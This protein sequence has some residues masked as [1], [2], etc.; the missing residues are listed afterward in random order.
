MDLPRLTVSPQ[1]EDQVLSS[2]NGLYNYLFLQDLL[3]FLPCYFNSNQVE[4][5]FIDVVDANDVSSL[6]NNFSCKLDLKNFSLDERLVVITE[7]F[8]FV[9]NNIN[10]DAI[11][12]YDDK[13][14]IHPIK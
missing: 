5:T 6:T 12:V 2:N 3:A 9:E 13:L 14:Y 4:F 8:S 10:C 7:I 11:F 1:F